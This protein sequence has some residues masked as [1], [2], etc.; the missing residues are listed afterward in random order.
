VIILERIRFGYLRCQSYSNFLT[1]VVAF[2]VIDSSRSLIAI[3]TVL[4]SPGKRQ[5]VC[6]CMLFGS[7]ELYPD[8]ATLGVDVGGAHLFLGN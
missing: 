2:T 1:V 4:R 5:L 8:I 6:H 7:F 3:I